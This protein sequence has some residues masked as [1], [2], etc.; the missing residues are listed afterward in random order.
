MARA[1]PGRSA[2][3]LRRGIGA[4]IAIVLILV[5]V[6]TV[7]GI[8][9]SFFSTHVVDKAMRSSAGNVAL[10]LAESAV[11]EL[12]LAVQW[13][14]NRPGEAY[15]EGLRRPVQ[16][17]GDGG[18]TLMSANPPGPDVPLPAVRR[19][20]SMPAYSGFQIDSILAEVSF[21]RPLG[22]LTYETEGL[23]RVGAKVSSQRHSSVVRGV[24]VYR[25]FKV[26]LVSPPRPFDQLSFFLFQV[27]PLLGTSAGE[28]NDRI[29]RAYDQLRRMVE[30]LLPKLI[31]QAQKAGSEAAEVE[32][33]ANQALS[34]LKPWVPPSIDNPPTDEV[35]FAHKFKEPLLLIAVQDLPRLEEIYLTP[36]IQANRD[37]IKAAEADLEKKKQAAESAANGTDVAAGKQAALDL[38]ASIE[39]LGGRYHERTELYR[40]FQQQFYEKSG[41][42]YRLWQSNFIPKLDKARWQR[43]ATYV[44]DSQTAFDE[45]WARL[46]NRLNGIVYAGCALRLPSAWKGKAV[47]AAT[48][49][50][51]LPDLTIQDRTKDQL[52]VIGFS[53]IV[54]EGSKCDAAIIVAPGGDLRQSGAV[55]YYG[56]L[57]FAGELKRPEQLKGSIE[58]NRYLFSGNSEDPKP[59]LDHL[60]VAVS[61]Q[62]RLR[63][64]YRR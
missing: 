44:V 8:S 61:P 49:A 6:M 26:V 1:H 2:R 18:F 37:A 22:G 16:G 32:S 52:T 3:A 40:K 30:E 58:R 28:A 57:V 45:L 19:L 21:R 43:K 56:Q 62:V 11:Q 50:V 46:G 36:A 42:A 20:S 64:V 5:A 17:A 15:Y 7:M 47:I 29:V 4:L 41:N 63:G 59:K 34:K 51:G 53:E 14:V 55:K 10:A 35:A 27:D 39:A 60:M 23:L 9:Q 48:Q 33:R 13:E 24:D 12:L 38:I 25:D 31:E 54:V